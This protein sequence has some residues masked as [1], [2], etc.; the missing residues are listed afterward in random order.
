MNYAKQ[1]KVNPAGAGRPRNNTVAARL[2]TVGAMICLMLTLC[3]APVMAGTIVID[4]FVDTARTIWDVPPDTFNSPG[5]PGDAVY[6]MITTTAAVPAELGGQRDL[7]VE[8]DPRV[9][10][11]EVRD[12]T[13]IMG[14]GSLKFLSA[15]SAGVYVSLLYE[16]ASGGPLQTLDLFDGTNTDFQLSFDSIDG[17]VGASFTY[18]DIFLTSDDGATVS[19]AQWLTD[20][21]GNPAGLFNDAAS[22]VDYF[23]PFSDFVTTSGV[24]DF[25]NITRVQVDFNFFDPNDPLITAI[26]GVD[27]KLTEITAV[28]VVIPEPASMALAMMGVLG[29]TFGAIGRRRRRA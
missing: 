18:V 2:A 11:L 28:E 16:D 20:P 19:E 29:A 3:A 12:A 27:F 14:N 10:P 1:N 8:V 6:N 13:G 24:I 21:V 26:P 25:S 7:F 4:D 22:P 17:G 9:S 15:S 5:V 23:I